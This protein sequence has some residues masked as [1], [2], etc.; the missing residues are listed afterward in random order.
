[1]MQVPKKNYASAVRTGPSTRAK[2]I[3]LAG[4]EG[5]GK[6]TALVQC[7]N[8]IILCAEDGL[9]YPA[10]AGIANYTPEDWPD[11]F[12]FIDYLTNSS[13]DFQTLGIDTLDW[14]EQPATRY[15]CNRDGKSNIEDY[16]YSKGQAVILPNEFRLLLSKLELLQQK[17]NMLI[18]ITA[19]I[20]VKTFNNPAG[21]NYDRF[22]ASGTKQVNSLIKQWCDINL[23]A[24]FDIATFKESKKGK[25]KGVGGDKRIVHTTYSAAFDAK[26]RCGL[27]NVLPFDMPTILEAIKKGTPDSAEN[28]YADA[29]EK[30]EKYLEGDTKTKT[31][32]YLD[33]NKN[34]VS[35][36]LLALNKLK[37]IEDEALREKKENEPEP[38]AQAA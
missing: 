22:E 30:A 5:V 9:T 17:K 34:N 28:L 14:L 10:F 36:L 4:I 12:G 13:H 15:I 24:T 6:T 2:R 32:K 38:A 20:M 37:C 7:P 35:I 26:N 11:V 27:P 31:L 3:F 25:A 29:K 21:D 23:F 18:V 1:M 16:G 8:P 19:H 33:T